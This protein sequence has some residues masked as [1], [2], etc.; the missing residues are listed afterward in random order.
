MTQR[1]STAQPTV[2]CAIYTRKSTEEGLEQDFNSLDAQRE[3]SEA[4][5]ASQAGEGWV[6]LPDRYD[7]GGFTGGNME[8]PALRRLMTDI[9]VGKIDCVAVY[10][11]DRLSRSL[12]DFARMVEVFEKHGVSFVSV[13]QQINTASSAGR[14]MLNVLLSFAQ[15]ERE[16]I[17]ERTRDKIAAARRKGKWVGGHPVLGYDIEP[18]EHKLVVN[19]DEA[20][21]VREMF[22]LYLEHE[23]LV[24]TVRILNER[25][26]S[27]KR[28]TTRKGKE[29]GGRPFDKNRLHKLLTNVVYLGKVKYKDE[30]HEGEHD[31]IIAP[32]VWQRVQQVL[33]RNGRAGGAAVRNKYGALLKGLLRCAPCD[34]SMGHTYSS[35]NGTKRYRYYVCLG[36][37]KRG[38]HTCPSKSIP[39]EEIERLVVEQIRAIGRDPS[40]IAATIRQA[41]ERTKEQITQHEQEKTRLERELKRSHGQ[42]RKLVADTAS[43]NGSTAT[44]LGDL[45]ERIR[46]AE[47]RLTEIRED[48]LA[49][50]RQMVSTQ[51]VT[52]A[53]AAFDPIW[54]TLS[55]KEQARLVKL[56]IERVDYDGENGK[57]TMTFR[58]AGFH[59]LGDKPA[60]EEVAA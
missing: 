60:G 12:L 36:A 39:A 22:E 10:K 30:V 5:I 15:F 54:E 32:E 40:L 48:S 20:A 34:C 51:E 59:A 6:C 56:L 18:R 44:R 14:L 33:V 11:V 38:W 1:R 52:D 4:Y 16:I 46:I 49:L 21:Q 17:S 23:A 7:D 13:T 29:R 31:G 25:A 53:L 3:S 27:T 37:Q 58:P 55:P 19:G 26:W 47:Q 24:P 41:R 57:V 50:S 28:W 9:E 45:N 35:K 43:S 42:V 8:R 2:R